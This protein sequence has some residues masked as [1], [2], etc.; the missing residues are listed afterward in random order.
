MNAVE[1]GA[2]WAKLLIREHADHRKFGLNR[3]LGVGKVYVK[4]EQ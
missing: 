2:G 4:G 3:N 1:I